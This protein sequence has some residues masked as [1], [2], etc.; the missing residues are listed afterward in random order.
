M[1]NLFCEHGTGFIS[2]TVPRPRFLEAADS[3]DRTVVVAG[4]VVVGGTLVVGRL[5]VGTV[6]HVGSSRHFGYHPHL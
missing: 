1:I 5:V 2:V 3:P 6:R 4:G